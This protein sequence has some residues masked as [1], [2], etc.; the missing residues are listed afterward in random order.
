MNNAPDIRHEL[1]IAAVGEHLQRYIREGLPTAG[2]DGDPWLTLAYNKLEDRYEVWVED[3]GRSPKCVLRSKPFSRGEPSIQELCIHLRD[4]DL[5]K[6]SV[7]DV[8]AAVDAHNAATERKARESGF[9][10]QAAALE[11]VYWSVGKATGD[12]KPTFGYSGA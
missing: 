5:R 11:K 3:P 9:Q 12:Y 8:L 4:N 6:K 1:E 7:D 2:W 10:A